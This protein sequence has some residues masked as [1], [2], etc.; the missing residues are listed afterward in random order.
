MSGDALVRCVGDVDAFARLQW[1]RAPGLWP[2]M[3]DFSDLL[4][5]AAIERLLT[6]L[7]RR[8]T[9]RVVRDGTPLPPASYTL[10][11]RVGGAEI[12][13]VADVDRVL[14]LVAGG[15]T[16][17]AQGLQRHWPPLA[18]FCL[19][20]EATLDHPVQANAYLSPP[21]AAALGRHVD[22]HDV[23]VLQVAGAKAWDIDG[24]GDV[25]LAAGDVAYLPAG[26]AH[27]ARTATAMSLHITLGVL[28]TTYRDVLRRLVDDLADDDLDRPLPVGF[29]GSDGGRALV[30]GI[31]ARVRSAAASFGAADPRLVAQREVARRRRRA[32][33]RWLGRLAVAVD[34][35]AVD[36]DTLVRI[37]RPI[38][39]TDDG[40]SVVLDA[41]DRRLRLPAT[42]A[43]AVRALAGGLSLRVGDLPALDA[44]DR[45][46][47]VRRLVR[48]GVVAV[49][50]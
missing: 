50:R 38:T 17:V 1:G 41:P 22:G 2:G 47:V 34:P 26:T 14:D 36:D 8:P 7:G 29:T 11:T 16:V 40:A 21:G 45:L 31:E 6:D 33:R 48:E 24:L 39:V 35:D 12:D 13:D 5:V 32:R 20:L 44:S 23:L 25:T 27:S 19:D 42:T 49:E 9:F 3:D 10:R 37:R 46:V 18:R 4:D 30:A 15:A 28:T 43:A